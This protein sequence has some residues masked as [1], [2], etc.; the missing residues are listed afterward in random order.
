MSEYEIEGGQGHLS[1][2]STPSLGGSGGMLPLFVFKAP[3]LLACG[4]FLGANY[5]DTVVYRQIFWFLKHFDDHMIITL[6]A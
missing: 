2:I 6:Q 3:R 1:C 4:A 5:F